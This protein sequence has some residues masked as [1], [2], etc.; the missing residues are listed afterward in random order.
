M[1]QRKKYKPEDGLTGKT[2]IP[3]ED[4]TLTDDDK[5]KAREANKKAYSDL[6]LSCTNGISFGLIEGVD[7][8]NNPVETAV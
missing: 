6:I 1:A 2:T 5:K 8:D 3:K 7:S 4:A